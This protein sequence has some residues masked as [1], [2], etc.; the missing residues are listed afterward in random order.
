MKT[1]TIDVDGSVDFRV[2]EHAYNTDTAD[3]HISKWAVD[4]INQII[5]QLQTDGSYH[6]HFEDNGRETLYHTRRIGDVR[7][8]TAPIPDVFTHLDRMMDEY[9]QSLG[10]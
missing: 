6:V 7:H 5:D 9:L 8:W 4:A 10:A 3:P 1:L 2:D